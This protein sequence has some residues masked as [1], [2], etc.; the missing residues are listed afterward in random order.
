M[1]Y[2]GLEKKYVDLQTDVKHANQF[3]QE[4]IDDEFIKQLAKKEI[5]QVVVNNQE[6]M[7]PDNQMY[8]DIWLY[9]SL[10]IEMV[11]EEYIT[12]SSSL[13][14]KITHHEKK[15][16]LLSHLIELEGIDHWKLLYYG[17]Q[18]FIVGADDIVQYSYKVIELKNS[19]DQ[20]TIKIAGLLSYDKYII[21]KMLDQKFEHDKDE[22]MIRD[23]Q[24]YNKIWFYLLVTADLCK[25]DILP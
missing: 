9:L 25:A 6:M 21:E 18:Q 12:I 2:Y 24:K 23:G 15:E 5:N 14:T 8:N 11:I 7:M 1:L 13:N 3:Q 10:A 16:C 4:Q 17:F 19:T 20:F 22:I